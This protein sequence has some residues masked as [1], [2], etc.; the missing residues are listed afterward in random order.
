[1]GREHR[2]VQRWQSS[3]QSHPW[4]KQE[5]RELGSIAQ[6][7]RL[8]VIAATVA[9]G[10]PGRG[11]PIDIDEFSDWLILVSYSLSD[12]SAGKNSYLYLLRGNT[13]VIQIRSICPSF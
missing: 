13:Y 8:L 4:T 12:D 1:M 7:D 11:I 2:Q 6:S 10:G 9:A 5:V 3:R